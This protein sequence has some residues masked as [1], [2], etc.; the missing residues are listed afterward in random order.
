MPSSLSYSLP[1]PEAAG[2]RSPSKQR[3]IKYLYSHVS[4]GDGMMSK[5]SIQINFVV[6]T[7]RGSCWVGDPNAVVYGQFHLNGRSTIN[8]D[9]SSRPSLSSKLGR[10]LSGWGVPQPQQATIVEQVFRLLEKAKG[11]VVTIQKSTVFIFDSL[12]DHQTMVEHIKKTDSEH[13]EGLGKVTSVGDIVPPPSCS[14]CLEGVSQAQAQ[15]GGVARLPCSH[16]Y[17][18]N[19]ILPWLNKSHLCPICRH[20]GPISQAQLGKPSKPRLLRVGFRRGWWKRFRAS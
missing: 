20:P 1:P 11:V 8:D 5:D 15:S 16:I 13:F 2:R 6:Q 3:Q 18:K 19:C 14:I 4:Q 7:S 9:L 17:H 10:K 12:K